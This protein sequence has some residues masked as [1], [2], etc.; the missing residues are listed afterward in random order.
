MAKLIINTDIS[1]G[2]INK[3]IYG[4]FS[5]HLGRCIYG[6]IYVGEDS[7]IPNIDGMRLDVV[8]ALRKIHVPVLR[9][10]GGCFADEYHWE[11]GIGPKEKRPCMVNT[12]WGGVTEDN[13]FGVVEDNS[14]GTHEFM[15]FCELIGA[16]PYINGNL[17]S[18]T[19]RE[20]Q[21]WVEYMTFDGISPMSN[22]RRENG[23]EEPWKVKYFGIGN[24]NWGCGGSMRP[25]YYADEYRRYATYVRNFG[26]NKIYRIA[27][28]PNTADYHWMEILM[29]RAADAMDGITLHYYTTPGEWKAKTHAIGFDVNEWYSTMK[30]TQYMEELVTRHSAIMDQYD[31]DKRVGLLVD[32][33][34]TWHKCEEGTNPGFLYQQNTLRDALVAGLNLNIFNNHCDRVQMSNIAQM[35]N[36]LQ[37]VILT[38]GEKMILTP[39]YYVYDMYQAHQDAQR[40]DA[41]LQDVPQVE[42]MDSVT[43]SVSV[44][45]GKVLAT[46]C[47][48]DLE[49]SVTVDLQLR[50]K[51]CASASATTLTS[52][53]MDQHNTFEEP[54]RLAPSEL[55]VEILPDGCHLT[56]PPKSV[57]ALV[58]E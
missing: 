27:C 40:V 12:H 6:G 43:V 26:D 52:D 28:G 46:L 44:K 50:G 7:E 30:K 11:D 33:W 49:N 32:E 47:N 4:H 54:E 29:S 31:P 13:S 9:W 34:G 51:V 56:L 45:D 35:V 22:L 2:K 48:I 19:V 25:E 20:M 3:N 8:E 16:E 17:G 23:R 53:I 38:E 15:R 37:S 5:E 14:F 42:N 58:L 57:T 24:E 21:Q 36:V 55:A 1:R 10:P 18:G 39:T 41:V